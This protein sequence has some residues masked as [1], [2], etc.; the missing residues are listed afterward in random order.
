VGVY[1]CRDIYGEVGPH[2]MYAGQ[3]VNRGK[4]KTLESIIPSYSYI[5]SIIS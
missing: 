5:E 2:Y 3:K 1:V 4:P